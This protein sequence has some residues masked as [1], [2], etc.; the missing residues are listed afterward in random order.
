MVAMNR[1][2]T[3]TLMNMSATL[4]QLTQS[5]ELCEFIPDYLQ[6]T[7]DLTAACLVVVSAVPERP[8]AILFRKSTLMTATGAH[9]KA[10]SMF[11]L[12]LLATDMNDL[13][14]LA[15]DPGVTVVEQ[16]LDQYHHM[17]LILH[18]HSGNRQRDVAAL[19][20]LRLTGDFL[21]QGL[22]VLLEWECHPGAIGNP[23]DQLNS[24]EWPV[25]PLY[26]IRIANLRFSTLRRRR[27]CAGAFENRCTSAAQIPTVSGVY[28]PESAQ[29]GT[30]SQHNSPRV[31]ARGELVL[32]GYFT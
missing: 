7:F 8:T 10:Q 21:T 30:F 23:F 15:S 18:L 26:M 22:Q 1:S 12:P 14:L 28:T 6:Q 17:M 32:L 27:F 29:L 2:D 11:P 16:K 19:E 31:I 4:G 13:K 24:R 3:Q 25:M 5:W 9:A 20:L